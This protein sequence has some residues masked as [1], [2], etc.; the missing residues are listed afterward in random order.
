MSQLT[1]C[2]QPPL[3]PQHRKC[4]CRRNLADALAEEGLPNCCEEGVEVCVARRS[5]GWDQHSGKRKL[6]VKTVFL[7]RHLL[8]GFSGVR[9]APCRNH[10]GSYWEHIQGNK[11]NF[12]PTATL[13]EPT[14]LVMRVAGSALFSYNVC[15][16]FSL[17]AI[18]PAGPTVPKI[19]GGGP[20]CLLGA[21]ILQS[22]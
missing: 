6:T 2:S 17:I 13:G 16:S 12:F 10:S 22:R 18:P 5:V 4:L 1:H 21:K 15:C 19:P 7:C 9:L 3:A 8:E 11:S 14:R 20:L